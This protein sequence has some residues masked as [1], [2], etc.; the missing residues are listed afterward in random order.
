[1]RRA[2]FVMHAKFDRSVGVLPSVSPPDN[3]GQFEG[4]P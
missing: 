4:G 2:P 1:M 3:Y